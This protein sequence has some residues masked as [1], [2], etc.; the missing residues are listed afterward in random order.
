MT[1]V[2][3]WNLPDAGDYSD[4]DAYNGD[5]DKYDKRKVVVTCPCCQG[6]SS[7]LCSPH[8]KLTSEGLRWVGCDHKEPYAAFRARCR[9]CRKEYRFTT[10]VPQ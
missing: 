2:H 4:E 7:P 5:T 6:T 3:E 1:E 10:Y 9:R 8:T